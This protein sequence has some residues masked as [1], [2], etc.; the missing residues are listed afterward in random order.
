MP[1]EKLEHLE[2]RVGTGLYTLGPQIQ[3]SQMDGAKLHHE[4]LTNAVD[5]TGAAFLGATLG[6]AR[7]HNHKFDPFTQKDYYGLQA[8]LAAS[9]PA[10]I[11]YD[12]RRTAVRNMIRADVPE[13]VAMSI[14]G[15]RTRAVFDRYNIVSEKD[16]REAVLKTAAYIESL[17]ETASVVTITQQA[18]T[19]GIP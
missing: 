7:C 18:A 19:G 10:N 15:H 6:C 9:Q 11:P 8:I 17:L 4:W 3:E 14:S 5:T 13:K 1:L 12:L 2:A 16:L